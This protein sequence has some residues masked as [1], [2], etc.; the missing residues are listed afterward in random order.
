MAR[1]S[2]LS[3]FFFSR[4]AR[5]AR[6]FADAR[7][8]FATT[9]TG[10]KNSLPPTPPIS[11]RTSPN[12]RKCANFFSPRPASGRSAATTAASA[13][14]TRERA[15]ADARRAGVGGNDAPPSPRRRRERSGAR[16]GRARTPR[17]RC[18][19]RGGGDAA[20]RSKRYAKVERARPDM[21]CVVRSG[22]QHRR[23]RRRRRTCA[24]RPRHPH[25]RGRRAASRPRRKTAAP[26]ATA[27]DRERGRGFSRAKTMHARGGADD[28]GAILARGA[29]ASPLPQTSPAPPGNTGATCAPTLLAG[30][31]AS[32]SS[33]ERPAT[34]ATRRARPRYA[35]VND[36][37]A[38]ATSYSH[39]NAERRHAR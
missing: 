25:Q 12:A 17:R 24:L 31:E 11:R 14:G 8:A 34:T 16:A 36:A 6:A 2:A 15:G 18:R 4:I 13:T 19:E 21:R 29:A 27:R 32:S 28:A 1:V 23:C 9:C 30:I 5:C 39:S 38:N 20:I 10:K 7:E 35:G 3:R 37:P 22:G 26:T 33:G